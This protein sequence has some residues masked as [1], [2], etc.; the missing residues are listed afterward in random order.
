MQLSLI[1]AAVLIVQEFATSAY[2]FIIALQQNY[3][4]WGIHLIWF[5]TT[6]LDTYVGYVI[7]GFTR[8]RLRGTKLERW[9]E[10]GA[11]RARA[12]LGTHAEKFSLALLGVI[13]F[14][15]VNGFLGAWIG[16]PLRTTILLTLAG[17]F[18]WYLVLWG[19]VLGIS[20]FVSNPD[21]IILI[22]LGVGILSHFLF[23]LFRANKG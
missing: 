10:K 20:A 21:I 8:D 18:V 13:D 3:P 7:G 22:L 11:A 14:P 16:L 5:A 4:M 6:L 2:V 9:I 15:Y 12:A 1:I 19:T 23:R 17:N